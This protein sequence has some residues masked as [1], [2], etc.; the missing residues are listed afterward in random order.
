[1]GGREEKFYQVI[2]LAQSGRLD[3]AGAILDGMLAENPEDP[4]ANTLRATLLMAAHRAHDALPLF[5]RAAAAKAGDPA[6]HYNYAR[7]LVSC[8]QA[9]AAEPHAR[10]ALDAQP[11][12]AERCLLLA[13]SLRAQGRES[14]AEALLAPLARAQPTAL[15]LNELGLCLS[16]QNRAE[17][18][19][20]AF[21]GATGLAP[22][23]AQTWHNLGNAL[24][25][26]H[27]ANEAIDAFTRALALTPGH[28][29]SHVHR[30]FALLL[31]GR[32]DE[33]FREYEWRWKLGRPMGTRDGLD[34][35]EWNGGDFHGRRLLLYGEQGFGD[36]IQ[37][38]RFVPLAAARGGSVI[39]DV[40]PELQR[41]AA[42]VADA[43]EVSRQDQPPPAHDLRLPLMSLP[44]VLGVGLD[45][46]PA[47][48]YLAAPDD[49]GKWRARLAPHPGRKIG[50]VWT[51]VSTSRGSIFKPVPFGDLA[52]LF[53][54]PGI[55]WICLQ[56]QIAATDRPLPPN[57]LN[58]TGELG[59]F[60]DTAALIGELEMVVS[61]DTAVAHLTGAL[62]RPLSALLIRGADWRWL[63][64][65][66]DSPWYPTARLY[67]QQAAG[68]WRSAVAALARDLAAP[69]P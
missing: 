65:R 16:D 62:G 31:A 21:R 54:I 32:Y 60:A 4:D 2:S 15:V 47:A 27:R 10:A 22:E 51:A 8:G 12:D 37:F 30:A 49:G 28:A 66:A 42:T 50:L 39:I 33:G 19:E 35:P 64:G 36:A 20:A 13:T 5:A 41:L 7:A 29:E 38:L 26:Q 3:E 69:A 24:L 57:L 14:E 55:T 23:L 59:D 58:V 25:D 63:A 53:D 46:L 40:A 34:T 11:G 1:M 45:N 68:D 61:V 17:E 48:P 9:A 18:A 6:F 56:K 43:A 67:R 52:P 44:H